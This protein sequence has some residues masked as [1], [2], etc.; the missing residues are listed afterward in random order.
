M[1]HELMT[2]P[3]LLSVDN[4]QKVLIMGGG[5]GLML[6]QILKH[7]SVRFVLQIELDPNVKRVVDWFSTSE[8]LIA[9]RHLEMERHRI[10]VIDELDARDIPGSYADS[11][12]GMFDAILHDISDETSQ[13]STPLYDLAFLQNVVTLLLSKSGVFVMSASDASANFQ[14]R[15]FLMHAK[16]IAAIF[17]FWSAIRTR[18]ES[19]FTEWGILFASFHREH[20][21]QPNFLF[22]DQNEPK[23]DEEASKDIINSLIDERELGSR[24]SFYD[25]KRHVRLSSY[26]HEVDTTQAETFGNHRSLWN[27]DAAIAFDE[28]IPPECPSHARPTSING[29]RM[30]VGQHAHAHLATCAPF[31]FERAVTALD[32]VVSA[33]RMTVS[34]GPV[35]TRFISEDAST[36]VYIIEESHISLHLLWGSHIVM[37]VFTCGSQRASSAMTN[38]LIRFAEMMT[39]SNAHV[40]RY[41]RRAITTGVPSRQ[42][43]PTVVPRVTYIANN[44]FRY[45]SMSTGSECRLAGGWDALPDDELQTNLLRI[46]NA[47]TNH[48]FANPADRALH[49]HRFSPH[50]FSAVAVAANAHFTIHTWPE[51]E[52]I[53]TDIRL[54]GNSDYRDRA[55][56]SAS[57]LANDILSTEMKC[58][59]VNVD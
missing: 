6:D 29:P 53:H 20:N 56:R 41:D 32:E 14:H 46:A 37:D 31:R 30:L 51:R 13:Y 25:G 55:Y 48:A 15:G 52:Q 42:A 34:V 26:M 33:L 43:P 57:A 11:Y 47:V 18:V 49:V 22:C 12:A 44:L 45:V 3:A 21:N 1:Y 23:C 50:G 58:A 2:H 24:L 39:C 35:S 38:A 10:V 28:N 59:Y 5:D 54:F 16:N 7:R 19:F 40:E 9:R 4:P 36:I 17:P 8:R 27:K